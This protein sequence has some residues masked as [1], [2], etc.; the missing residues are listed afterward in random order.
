[1]SDNYLVTTLTADQQK[2]QSVMAKVQPEGEVKLSAAVRVAQLSLKHRMV[3]NNQKLTSLEIVNIHF[4]TKIIGNEL[5]FSSALLF[6]RMRRI[7]S[8]LPSD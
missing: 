2:F 1:M 6:S 5:S 3:N 7:L 8:K 4:S